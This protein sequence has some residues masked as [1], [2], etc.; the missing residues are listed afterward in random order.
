MAPGM[1]FTESVQL[2]CR[3]ALRAPWIGLTAWRRCSEEH[4]DHD[5]VGADSEPVLVLG[6]FLSHPY[7]Y[8]PLGR[9]LARRGY[10]VHFDDVFNARPL[11]AHVARLRTRVDRIV[12]AS[13]SPLRVVGHSLGGIQAMVLLLEQPDA[14]GQVIAVA[15]P[16]VGGTPWQPLQR[17]VERVLRVRA[18][19]TRVLERRLAPY[20]SR[21]TTISSPHDLVAPPAACT[22]SGA[23][24]VVLTSVPDSDHALASHGGVIFM[25]A[26]VRAIMHALSD[27]VAARVSVA[28]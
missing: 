24:N 11:R 12:Q 20:A 9:M 26:A 3:E 15:S 25:R 5:P 28:L 7:Y 27:P 16:V 2:V 14:I 19:D 10:A 17:L 1:S 4:R 22:V 6:G 8:A 23:A 21:I 18:D 13:G